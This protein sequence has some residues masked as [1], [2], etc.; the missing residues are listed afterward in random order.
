M[1][2][3]HSGT[4][5]SWGAA[6]LNPQYENVFC[7]H[8]KQMEGWQ[9]GYDSSIC[10]VCAFQ[11]WT[12]RCTFFCTEDHRH[13]LVLSLKCCQGPQC[14]FSLLCHPHTSLSEPELH[15]LCKKVMVRGAQKKWCHL[16]VAVIM[17]FR[18]HISR[19]ILRFVSGTTR[20]KQRRQR[21]PKVGLEDN[22]NKYCIIPANYLP[23]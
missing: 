6:Q 18:N 7:K 14:P 16:K 22:H 10:S 1:G 8:R 13:T 21:R 23:H 15:F 17:M 12:S 5:P 9:S 3:S 19:H 2:F 4:Y 20:F 11:D